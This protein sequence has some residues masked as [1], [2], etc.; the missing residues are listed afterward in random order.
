M[1]SVDKP[2]RINADSL[3]AQ[4][5]AH[6]SRCQRIAREVEKWG[7]KTKHSLDFPEQHR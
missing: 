1:Q 4:Y 3:K 2:I 6:I 5:M 7:K